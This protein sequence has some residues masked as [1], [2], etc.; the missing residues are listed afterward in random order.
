M[1]VVDIED[2]GR[3]LTARLAFIYKQINVFIYVTIF[4]NL[5][6]IL[7]RLCEGG[8]EGGREGE[9]EGG[10]EGGREGVGERKGEDDL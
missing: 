6:N 1:V 9:R 8:R 2:R 4:Q 10:R 3:P 7:I 5:P